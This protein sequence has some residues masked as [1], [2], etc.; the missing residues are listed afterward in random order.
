MF[1]ILLV[2]II[3]LRSRR[4]GSLCTPALIEYLVYRTDLFSHRNRLALNASLRVPPLA[5]LLLVKMV[6]WKFTAPDSWIPKI[7]NFLHDFYVF[8]G[9]PIEAR[10]A[11]IQLCEPSRLRVFA[12]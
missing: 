2:A 11:M 7:V 10:Q 9:S 8:P 5:P 3:S 12:A 1:N 6:V 4:I